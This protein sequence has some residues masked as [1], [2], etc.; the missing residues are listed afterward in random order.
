MEF[1][2]ISSRI[3]NKLPQNTAVGKTGSGDFRDALYI[4]KLCS[5]ADVEDGIIRLVSRLVRTTIHL[6]FED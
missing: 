6:S 5:P 4:V 3:I 2:A 1:E